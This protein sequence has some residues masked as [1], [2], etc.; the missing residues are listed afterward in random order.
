MTRR[1]F[2]VPPRFMR[3]FNRFYG[4]KPGPDAPKLDGLLWFR[5]YYLRGLVPIAVVYGLALLL[6]RFSWVLYA[7]ISLP[8][9]IGFARLSVEIRREQRSPRS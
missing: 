4:V 7:V 2:I 3:A 5:S 6:T 1:T 8:W 9:I